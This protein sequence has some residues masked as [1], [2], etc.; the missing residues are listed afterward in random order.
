MEINPVSYALAVFLAVVITA[1][2]TGCGVT[3]GQSAWGVGESFFDKHNEKLKIMEKQN[4]N[5]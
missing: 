4:D 1:C 3:M 2:T 5:Q